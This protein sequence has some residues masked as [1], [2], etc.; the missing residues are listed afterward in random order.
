MS[1]LRRIEQGQG[2]GQQDGNPSSPVQPSSGGEGQSGA[3]DFIS[4]F[5]ITSQAG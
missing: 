5:F 3:G 1:L 4:P 2:S